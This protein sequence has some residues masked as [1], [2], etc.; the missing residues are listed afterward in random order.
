MRSERLGA[1]HQRATR[2]FEQRRERREIARVNAAVDVAHDLVR[3]DD[4]GA[5]I[6][7][8]IFETRR[9]PILAE[10]RGL[11][12]GT[13]RD[14]R[15]IGRERRQVEI[16]DP[17]RDVTRHRL[18]TDA[19]GVGIMTRAERFG[20]VAIADRDETDRDPRGRELRI[21]L[22]QLRERLGKKASTDVA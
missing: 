15:A 6:A 2:G 1:L 18:I 5:R 17:H 22:A 11:V 20:F 13:A 12:L 9:I 14:E 21:E 19:D 7:C 4:R 16:V 10:A 3:I 8:G